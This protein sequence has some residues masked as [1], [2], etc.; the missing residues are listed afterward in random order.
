[1]AV[2]PRATIL[3]TGLAAAEI[4]RVDGG[5]L[6]DELSALLVG[7]RAVIPSRN[8]SYRNMIVVIVHSFLYCGYRITLLLSVDVKLKGG[9]AEEVRRVA[10]RL[11]VS[12]I[13]LL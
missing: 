11:L 2:P 4:V 1:M 8:F 9:A 10:S 7:V 3:V 5:G 12:L 6:R 13:A